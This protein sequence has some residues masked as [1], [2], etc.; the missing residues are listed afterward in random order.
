VGMKA[1]YE[2][3]LNVI[4]GK[5][6]NKYEL[7]ELI[8]RISLLY[9]PEDKEWEVTYYQERKGIIFNEKDRDYEKA[10]KKFL[11]TAKKVL[12]EIEDEAF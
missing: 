4:D 7:G 2:I 12:K 9:E 1:K 3:T 10:L 11:E 5:K 6:G 8:E